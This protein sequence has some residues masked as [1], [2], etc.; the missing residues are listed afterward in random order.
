MAKKNL[1]S[2]V[3]L[4]LISSSVFSQEI[5]KEQVMKAMK[6]GADYAANVLLDENGKSR[7][8]YNVIEG[9]WYEYLRLGS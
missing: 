8:D 6:E 7:C 4:L 3:L 1:L 2:A 9:K 5:T